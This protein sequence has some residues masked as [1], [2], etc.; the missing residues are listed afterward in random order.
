MEYTNGIAADQSSA[1]SMLKK[2]GDKSNILFVRVD[3]AYDKANVY[4]QCK[5]HNGDIG[6][7]TT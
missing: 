6:H 4:K 7:I 1:C 5:K 2:I 3:S